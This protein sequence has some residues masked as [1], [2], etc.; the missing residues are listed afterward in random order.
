MFHDLDHSVRV[1]RGKIIFQDEINWAIKFL[2]KDD[3]IV[4]Y[5]TV[6]QKFVYLF[7]SSKPGYKSK[8]FKLKSSR[9]LRGFDEGRIL[10]DFKSFSHDVWDIYLVYRKLFSFFNA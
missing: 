2:R 9:K 1:G 3:R 4:W 8:K 7:L 10:A 5:L 6:I